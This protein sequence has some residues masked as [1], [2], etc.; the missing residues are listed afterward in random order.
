MTEN[1][2]PI[3]HAL[4]TLASTEEALRTMD[5][6]SVSFQVGVQAWAAIWTTMRPDIE[7]PEGQTYV[8]AAIIDARAFLRVHIDEYITWETALHQKISSTE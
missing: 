2:I 7:Q 6:N 8:E 3:A 1:L 5:G 4:T